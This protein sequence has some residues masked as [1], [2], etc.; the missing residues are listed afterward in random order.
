MANAVSNSKIDLRTETIKKG[1]PHTLRLTKTRASY[2]RLFK[3]WEE[4]VE[5]LERLERIYND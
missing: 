4:D 3:K 5:Y 1:S 2:L